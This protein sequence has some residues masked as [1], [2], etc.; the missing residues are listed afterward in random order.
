MRRPLSALFLL[1]AALLLVA[2][3]AGCASRGAPE[4]EAGRSVDGNRSFGDLITDQ[5][6]RGRIQGFVLQN[7][8][9]LRE[10][11]VSITVF[12]RVVLLTGEV[13]D[14]PAGRRLAAF[15]RD[16]EEVRQVYNELMVAP[17]S[18][19]MSRSRDRM[20]AT[21]AGARLL[22]LDAPDGFDA[23]RIKVVTER[24]RIYLL[25]RVTRSEADA[26]TESLRRISGVR[27]VVRMFEYL[28]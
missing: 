7:D 4:S 18:S 14:A 8:A 28:D 5:R 16:Q 26:V 24:Q 13:V 23:D 25:G 27:E 9:L 19:V 3:L 11:N 2:L 17:L 21:S 6:L 10:S 12:N 22:T 1:L 15:A 20:I